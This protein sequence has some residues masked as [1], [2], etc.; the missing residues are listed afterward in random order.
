MLQMRKK[1]NRKFCNF[2]EAHFPHA[3]NWLRKTMT[4]TSSKQQWQKEFKINIQM[5]MLRQ[6]DRADDE[7]V[8]CLY[9]P[10]YAR[11]F[12]WQPVQRFHQVDGQ[13]FCT[14]PFIYLFLLAKTILLVTRS[15][16]LLQLNIRWIVYIKF[17][18][19]LQLSLH[20]HSVHSADFHW[21]DCCL[22]A[23]MTIN[24]LIK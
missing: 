24:S 10:K 14:I 8:K 16:N 5:A 6:S 1:R 7:E 17:T 23:T 20:S 22:N 15:Q 12:E 13:T 3:N 2:A 19:A 21:E 4:T 18:C 9:M 11:K